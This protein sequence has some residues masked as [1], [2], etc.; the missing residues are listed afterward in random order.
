MKTGSKAVACKLTTPELQERKRTVIA[1]L[2]KAL[3]DK[4]ETKD[5]FKYKFESS[6][7]LIDKVTTFVKTERLCC[8]FFDFTVSIT[9]ETNEMWL[10]LSGPEGTKKFIAEEIGF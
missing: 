8:E 7:E 3:L 10:E 2:K 6:D 4:K 1:E 5:G 9:S